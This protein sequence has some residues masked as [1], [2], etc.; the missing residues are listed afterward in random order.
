MSCLVKTPVQDF[1][2]VP[3]EGLSGPDFREG[4]R[5]SLWQL[6]DL[7]DVARGTRWTY[8]PTEGYILAATHELMEI[9]TGLGLFEAI[10]LWWKAFKFRQ[11]ERAAESDRKDCPFI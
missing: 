1:E 10:G 6:H 2:P 4:T 3:F 5:L 9:R 7:R 11:R 8:P